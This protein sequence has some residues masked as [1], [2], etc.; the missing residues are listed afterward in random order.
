MNTSVPG[1]DAVPIRDA[2]SVVLLRQGA[3]G[4]ET[5]T[6]TRTS[7]MVFAAGAM[8]FPGG[9]VDPSDHALPAGEH[10]IA[11]PS[12]AP[13][14]AF[15]DD[16]RLALPLAAAAVRET[17]EE[18]GVLLGLPKGHPLPTED[19]RDAARDA[20][21]AQK[22][23]IWDYFGSLGVAP[24]L[25]ALHRTGRW[26]TPEGRTRRYD[27]RFFLAE[28]PAGQTAVL[29]TTEA[30]QAQWITPQRALELF[31]RGETQLMRPTEYLIRALSEFRTV[32]DALTASPLQ[33]EATLPRVE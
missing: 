16:A 31:D 13:A 12:G 27:A 21:E 2:A 25:P 33:R 5:F 23:S 32:E 17:F 3:E 24:D 1:A 10:Q 9:G 14:E 18:C 30:T 20:L 28:L 7:T 19:T 6:L 26:I 22:M 29:G 11:G 8:V 15:A 4:V